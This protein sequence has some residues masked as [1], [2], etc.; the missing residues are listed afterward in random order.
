MG[1]EDTGCHIMQKS[2]ATKKETGL[3]LFHFL[4][5]LPHFAT[6]FF[7]HKNDVKRLFSHGLPQNSALFFLAGATHGIFC[8]ERTLI[9]R[10]YKHPISDPPSPSSLMVLSMKAAV[11]VSLA[12]SSHEGIDLGLGANGTDQYDVPKYDHSVNSDR[13]SLYRRILLHGYL[14]TRRHKNS[15]WSVFAIF[16]SVSG[17]ATGI[18]HT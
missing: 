1:P 5:G 2:A 6:L 11:S 3:D 15:L 17:L 18:L 4:A 12:L 10:S 14:W 13:A 8:A 16:I 9:V 7:F